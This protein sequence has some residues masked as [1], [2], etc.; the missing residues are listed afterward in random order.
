MLYMMIAG[1]SHDTGNHEESYTS[2]QH[3]IDFATIIF[4][5]TICT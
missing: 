4:W 1:I 2:M 5:L 3:H